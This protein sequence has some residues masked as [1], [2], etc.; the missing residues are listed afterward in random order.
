MPAKARKDYYIKRTAKLMK[1]LSYELE[2]AREILKS[3]CGEAKIDELFAQMKAEFENIIPEIPYIGGN[4]SPFTSILVGTMTNLAMFRILEK[5][6]FK[7]RDIGEFYYKLRD[8]E[9][10]VRKE[11]LEK[12]NK[13]PAQN[14]FEPAY[15]EFMKKLCET[16]RL[17]NYPDDWV[18]DFIE[19]DGKN[20]EWG[21]KFHECGVQKVFK[22]LDAERF[23]PFICLSDFS[24]AN[25]LGFG[26]KR[27]QTLGF[28]APMCDHTYVKNY[29]TPKGWPPDNLPEFNKSALP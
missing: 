28:G 13:D 23:V 20:F 12:A 3:K 15:V 25:I 10:T 17:R 4:K 18:G 26:F 27:T 7:L 6:G 19:G 22:R 21:F 2:I 14:P 29:K 9:N 8:K 11:T 1:N 5:E 24:E 16:S